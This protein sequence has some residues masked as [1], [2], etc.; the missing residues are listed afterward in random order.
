MPAEQGAGDHAHL[1]AGQGIRDRGAGDSRRLSG[2]VLAR[3]PDQRGQGRSR[4]A[5]A[6]GEQYGPG[7]GTHGSAASGIETPTQSR[8]VSWRGP[9]TVLRALAILL[10][11]QLAGEAITRSL[12]WP[13]PG[14]VLGLVILVVLLFVVGRRHLVSSSTIDETSLGRMS[15]GLIATLGVL[16]VPAGVGVIQELGPL[17]QYGIALAAALLVSTVMTLVVTVWVFV[18]VSRLVERKR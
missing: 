5:A 15:N 4:R 16:F 11:C 13:L 10:A 3:R 7:R 6:A 18:G 12:D 2:P 9:V 8:T 14:P 17:G 1:A